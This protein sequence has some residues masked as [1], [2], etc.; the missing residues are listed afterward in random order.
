MTEPDKRNDLSGLDDRADG[1]LV[2]ARALRKAYRAKGDRGEFT[3]VDGIDFEVRRGEAFGL[4]GANGAGKSSTMR[5]IACVSPVSG[6]SL[7]VLGLDTATDGPRIRSR[8]GVVPQDDSVDT[9]LTVREN[10][11]IHGRY[12]GLSRVI[13]TTHYVT[14]P[15]DKSGSF[16]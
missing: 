9:E 1:P 6:G 5:M 3:A 10:L 4:L 11:L 2:E 8:P 15:P 14:P 12:F 13:L 16:S 7:R